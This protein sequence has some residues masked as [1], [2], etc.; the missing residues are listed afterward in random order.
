VTESNAEERVQLAGPFFTKAVDFPQLRFFFDSLCRPPC[1]PLCRL[2]DR[3]GRRRSGWESSRFLDRASL[4]RS[5]LSFHV[6]H[7]PQP[8]F[9]HSRRTVPRHFFFPP[10][11][12]AQTSNSAFF[13]SRESAVFFPRSAPGPRSPFPSSNFPANDILN[14]LPG[15]V[16]PGEFRLDNW[17]AFLLPSHPPDGVLLPVRTFVLDAGELKGFPLFWVR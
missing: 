17:P 6:S 2:Q 11:H 13:N 16:V 7:S 10:S 3:T 14:P 5:W 9:S 8:F 4:S 15:F 1:S 12:E